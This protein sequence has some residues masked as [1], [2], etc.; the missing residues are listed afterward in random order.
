[1]LDAGHFDGMLQEVL[2]FLLYV[3]GNGMVMVDF[4]TLMRCCVLVLDFLMMIGALMMFWLMMMM[5]MIVFMDNSGPRN[6]CEQRT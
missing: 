5:M 2:I 4:K 3:H 6:S 1:M